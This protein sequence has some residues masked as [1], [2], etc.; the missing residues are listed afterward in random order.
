MFESVHSIKI[1]TVTVLS[2]LV[3]HNSMCHSVQINRLRDSSTSELIYWCLVGDDT[4]TTTTT[5][6]V[7][8]I[9]S[10]DT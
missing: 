10:S 1:H 3:L 6:E 2:Y 7:T 9:D 4:K 5:N 8:F